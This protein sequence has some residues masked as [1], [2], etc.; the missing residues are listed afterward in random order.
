MASKGL[1][2]SG[3]RFVAELV[4]WALPLLLV[5]LGHS[6]ARTKAN[7]SD[8]GPGFHIALMTDRTLHAQQLW[9]YV[10]ERPW[11][12]ILYG[13]LLAIVLSTL[14]LSSVPTPYRWLCWV[15]V[16][17]PGLWYFQETAYLGAKVLSIS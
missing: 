13:G 17:L 11:L 1:K 12:F 9:H 5:V 8:S 7:M 2:T 3:V 15:V 14:I 16:T 10:N 4:A 6:F